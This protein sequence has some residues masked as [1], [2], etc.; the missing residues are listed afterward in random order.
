MPSNIYRH[1]IKE[2]R[3]ESIEWEEVMDNELMDVVCAVS[4]CRTAVLQYEVFQSIRQGLLEPGQSS[5]KLVSLGAFKMGNFEPVR[6]NPMGSTSY[7][8][9]DVSGHVFKIICTRG[10]GDCQRAGEEDGRS[11]MS[12]RRTFLSAQLQKVWEPLAGA[13]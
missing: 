4:W 5:S 1:G 7:L 12:C 11:P 13:L 8:Q 3:A 9:C 2:C 6:W 10:R